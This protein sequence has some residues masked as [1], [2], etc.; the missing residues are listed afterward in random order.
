MEL[1][2]RLPTGHVKVEG[3]TTKDLFK[4]AAEA[5]EVFGEPDCG[6]CGKANIRYVCRTVGKFTYYELACQD[7]HAKLQMGQ[8]EGG[9]LF[10]VRKL[11]PGGP[12]K[13][14][15]HYKDGEYDNEG[16]GWTHY[17]GKPGEDEGE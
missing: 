4:A 17:R 8:M 11:I 12:Q 14:K 10:P 7:C 1:A 2:I 16:R 3:A 13:G 15:P 9:K 5:Q 6:K